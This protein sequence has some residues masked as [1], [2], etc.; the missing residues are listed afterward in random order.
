MAHVELR[1]PISDTPQGW[2]GALDIGDRLF[3]CCQRSLSQHVDR[4]G[5]NQ[6]R[7]LALREVGERI[8][9]NWV[10]HPVFFECYA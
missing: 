6:E 2:V 10:L 8:F 9:R 4:P 3:L 1:Q 5:H 7:I